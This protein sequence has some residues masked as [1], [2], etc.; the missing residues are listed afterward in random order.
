[1]IELK[2]L[3]INLIKIRTKLFREKA[4]KTEPRNLKINRPLCQPPFTVL[5]YYFLEGGIK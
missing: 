4:G 5:A 3:P 1:M 2:K